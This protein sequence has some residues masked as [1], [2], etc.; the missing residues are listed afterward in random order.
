MMSFARPFAIVRRALVLMLVLWMPVTPA[1][2]QAPETK[3]P[4]KIV[5]GTMRVPPFVVRSDDGEWSGLSI[6]LW[7]EIAAELKLPYEFRAYDYDL[8]GLLDAVEQGKID[9]A[10]AAIPTRPMARRGSISAILISRPAL[11]SP[12][13]TTSRAACS[14]PSPAPLVP[15][16]SCPSARCS[17]CRWRSAS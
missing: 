16:L 2:A 3:T 8:E 7:K 1:H 9:A 6:D 13:A 10:I 17:A 15:R 5:V 11:A 14:G 12:C 4:A